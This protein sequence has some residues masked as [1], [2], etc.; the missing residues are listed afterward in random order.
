MLPARKQHEEETARERRLPLPS[1][2]DK[3]AARIAEDARRRPERYLE[4]SEVPAGG[5]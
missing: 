3:V 5:E 2:L 1:P 4:T